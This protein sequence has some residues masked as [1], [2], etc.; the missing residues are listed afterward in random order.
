MEAQTKILD[1]LCSCTGFLDSDFIHTVKPVLGGHLKR[2]N[3]G[4]NGK[5]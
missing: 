5:W 3:K 4:L 2:Q 1:P